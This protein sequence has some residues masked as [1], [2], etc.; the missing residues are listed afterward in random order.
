MAEVSVRPAAAGD[1]AEIARIQRETWQQAYA[2]WLP[3]VVLESATQ[4]VAQAT[5]LDAITTPPS[6]RYHVLVALEQQWQVGFAAFG[7]VLDE[8]SGAEVGGAGQVAALLVEPR[9]GR[10]GHGSRLLAAVVDLMRADGVRT[11]TVWVPE[12][13]AA[14]LAFYTSAGWERDGYARTLEGEGAAMTEVRLHVSLEE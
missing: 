13:D 10:R 1:A 14:S 12:Q 3:P 4:D 6:P 5:W 7:P 2:A 9:W 11:A 8:D